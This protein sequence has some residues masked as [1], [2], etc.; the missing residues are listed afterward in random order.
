MPHQ[1]QSER[2]NCKRTVTDVSVVHAVQVRVLSLTGKTLKVMRVVYNLRRSC[3]NTVNELLI[4]S[5]LRKS[6]LTHVYKL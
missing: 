5:K 1:K 3:T 6:R 2:F 4:S